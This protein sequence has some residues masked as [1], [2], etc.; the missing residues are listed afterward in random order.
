MDQL[1]RTI[2]ERNHTLASA[3]QMLIGFEDRPACF[4]PVPSLAEQITQ[5]AASYRVSREELVREYERVTG[6]RL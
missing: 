4:G 1:T 2:L 6:L 5:M 3:L